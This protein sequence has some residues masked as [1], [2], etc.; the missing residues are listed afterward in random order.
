MVRVL[1]RVAAVLS[2]LVA[3][4]A[5]A[6]VG[7]TFLE[8]RLIFHPSRGHSASP[9]ELGLAFE[10]L[11]LPSADGVTVHGYHFV[12]AG[13]AQARAHLLYSHGNAGNVS[14]GFYLAQQLVERGFGVLMYDYRGFGHSSDV[15]P[16]EA[17]AYADGEAALT[18]LVDRVGGPQRVVL[19]GHSLGGGVSY[20]LAA[21]HPELSGIIT[22]ATFTS[23]PGMVRGMPIVGSL[24]FLMRTRMDNLQRIAE[25]AMPK[26]IFH[27]TADETVP[28]SM[29]GELRDHARPPVELVTLPGAGHNNAFLSD[30]DRY[31]GALTRFVDGCVARRA[32]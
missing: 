24:A 9:E 5:A 11:L 16:T 18:A 29:A 21:R 27:G 31:F 1:R 20:E 25:V 4:V 28:Y 32:R 6:I 22:D 30:R 2:I 13:G 26:L 23:V 3:L 10:E 8:P 17:G 14:T 19:Y 7:L 12:P 15:A